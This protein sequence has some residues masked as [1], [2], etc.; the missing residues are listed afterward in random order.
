MKNNN[1]II[2]TAAEVKTLGG[3]ARRLMDAMVSRAAGERPGADI[4]REEAQG[5]RQA[6][7]Q[8]SRLPVEWNHDHDG[9]QKASFE[10]AGVKF[11]D[12][13]EED[14]IWQNVELPAGWEIKPTDHAMW[15]TVVD[16]RGRERAKFFYNSVP[17]SRFLVLDGIR[18][19]LRLE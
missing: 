9:K 11:G 17:Q 1:P 12:R 19:L 5:Q 6:C 18:G 10:K 13:V 14:K 15:N 16:E 4:E 3:A 2:N 8:T 7:S